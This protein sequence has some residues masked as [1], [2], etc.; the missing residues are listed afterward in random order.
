MVL[1][2]VL[3]IIGFGIAV[4]A[5]STTLSSR[6]NADRDQ[7]AKRAQQAADA[8][9]QTELYRVNQVDMKALQLSSGLSLRS[10][11]SQLLVC[12]VPQVN[13]AGGGQLGPLAFTYTVGGQVANPCPQNSRGGTASPLQDQEPVGDHA[14]FQVQYNPGLANVGDFV[15]F[16]P[17]IVASGVDDDGPAGISPR[18]VSQREEAIL[19]PFI[20][21]RTLEAVHDIKFDVPSTLN[22]LGQSVAGATAF[23]GTAAAGH[24][25]TIENASSGAATFTGTNISLSGGLT[26]PS[27]LDY[28]N[29]FTQT[30]VSLSLILGTPTA[31]SP[32]TG[33]VSR[34]PIAL[35]ESKPNCPGSCSAEFGSAYTTANGVPEIYNPSATTTLSFA[36]GDYVFCSFYSA[37]PVNMN[38][39]W[40]PSAGLGAVRIFIDS[41]RSANCSGFHG[42]NGISAGSFT[43]TRGV[44]N[45][46]ASTHP[47]QAQIY[48]VGDD[49]AHW[50][51][52]STPDTSVTATAG[53]LANGQ[54][55][56]VY[57][58]QSTVTVSSTP[59]CSVVFRVRV[60]CSGV[61][62][63]SGAYIGYDLNVSAASVAQDLGLLNYPLSNSLGP[64][65]VKRYV[66]CPA[67]YPLPSPATSG[68]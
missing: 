63:L 58:P 43:A 54:A 9:I 57:A 49:P 48:L 16:N 20:P 25:L 22:L 10:I 35:S 13:A 67:A 65:H 19:S 46:L 61:G 60:T 39:S 26:E 41:P 53:G 56:F 31:V 14:Y 28:C 66:E 37:G 36:P 1:V 47:S 27:T 29:K 11:I 3:M 5:L 8:G 44:T 18:Y 59:A 40:P 24:D 68:C 6:S 42:H 64:F 21:W 17:T 34:P 2:L 15:Q 4:A 30:N 23:N 62:S 38:P 52:S 33:L 12:P 55:A 50:S 45:L 32:C 51:D 7:R